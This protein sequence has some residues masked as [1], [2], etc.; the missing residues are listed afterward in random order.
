[1]D[2][3]G[4]RRTYPLLAYNRPWRLH[5]EA[6]A[7]LRDH[8]KP[9]EIIATS[10]PHWAYLKTGL[11]TVQPPWEHDPGTAQRLLEAV[12][13]DYLI[14]DNLLAYEL[15]EV[16]RVYSIPVGRAFPERW[17]LIHAVAD[18]SS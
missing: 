6:L 11:K 8:A 3:S 10:T 5:D 13:V 1:M 15:A 14:I 12:P 17:K 4:Q 7:W 2:G 16:A 18:S 9:G